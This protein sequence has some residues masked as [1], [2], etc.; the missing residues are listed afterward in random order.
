MGYFIHIDDLLKS[1]AVFIFMGL[2]SDEKT[3]T[4]IPNHVSLRAKKAQIYIPMC[5]F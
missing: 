1:L 2:G 4:S 5:L 3:K